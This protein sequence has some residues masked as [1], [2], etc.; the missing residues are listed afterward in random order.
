MYIVPSSGEALLNPN[1]PFWM[2]SKEI[3]S[4]FLMSG[5][6]MLH[7]LKDWWKLIQIHQ[8]YTMAL[9]CV[10]K[11][12]KKYIYISIIWLNLFLCVKKNA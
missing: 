11:K 4:C 3:W 9:I 1:L 10:K 2:D 8:Y 7:F 12:K 5:V 6:G